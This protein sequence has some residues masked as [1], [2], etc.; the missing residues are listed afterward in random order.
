MT[1]NNSSLDS[2]DLA[3]ISAE[4][5]N[6]LKH[7]EFGNTQGLNN[8]HSTKS[9]SPLDKKVKEVAA[10]TLSTQDYEDSVFLFETI[11][12]LAAIAASNALT[13]KI[14]NRTEPTFKKRYAVLK[15]KNENLTKAVDIQ[16]EKFGYETIHHSRAYH[17]SQNLIH[18]NSHV[19]EKVLGEIVTTLNDTASAS[20]PMKQTTKS[21][22]LLNVMLEQFA[23][24][25]SF[26]AANDVSSVLAETETDS[27]F[28]NINAL[29]FENKFPSNLETEV[30][31]FIQQIY[32][33]HPFTEEGIALYLKPL[34]VQRGT[35]STPPTNQSASTQPKEHST[36]NIHEEIEL[37][38]E[39]K[40][41]M[42]GTCIITKVISTFNKVNSKPVK[43]SHLKS[44]I[45]SYKGINTKSMPITIEDFLNYDSNNATL[46]S[47]VDNA[48]QI[49]TSSVTRLFVA[50]DTYL[51]CALLK[52]TQI[53]TTTYP[54]Q[55][56]TNALKRFDSQM[57]TNSLNASEFST[58]LFQALTDDSNKIINY[59]KQWNENFAD[60]PNSDL[61][62]VKETV[63]KI[64]PIIDQLNQATNHTIDWEHIINN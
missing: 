44:Q 14:T 1:A 31:N 52:N 59:L 45:S 20:D 64:R 58:E 7:K 25:N 4:A 34:L 21:I 62:K 47:H 12:W 3:T 41:K 18:G 37:S 48:T 30:K 55:N 57:A 26:N 22:D 17:Y 56:I 27:S 28:P 50:L 23:V 11:P 32:A 35:F 51:T 42:T 39:Q 24:T 16:N 29:R 33:D 15:S 38:I 19:G 13:R 8:V 63:T 49:D 2:H 43:S 10:N 36:L 9:N 61:D 40:K 54:L 53:K 46:L 60:L 5:E 6:I